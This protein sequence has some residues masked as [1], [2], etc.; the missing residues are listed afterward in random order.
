LKTIEEAK[1][2]L[3]SEQEKL[4]EKAHALFGFHGSVEGSPGLLSRQD[5]VNAIV[6]ATDIS[7]SGALIDLV[8]SQYST[9]GKYLSLNDF[10]SMVTSGLLF[11][12]SVGRYWVAISLAEAETIRRILHVRS[13]KGLTDLISGSNTEMALRYSPLSSL[14][15]HQAGDGGLVFDASK[16]WHTDGTKATQYEA[17]VSHSSFRFFDCDMHFSN[18]S[19]NILVRVLKARY[20]LNYPYNMH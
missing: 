1:P 9:D 16:L 18:A 14:S 5:L 8:F 12:E 15:S 13:S 11:P 6:S 7:P 2:V 3:T 19:L 4:L 20:T 10:K 17:A